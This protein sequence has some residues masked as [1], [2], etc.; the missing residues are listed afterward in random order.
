MNVKNESGLTALARAIDLASG[1]LAT[2][3][4]ISYGRKLLP[5]LL[6]YGADTTLRLPGS[7][8]TYDDYARR[9]RSGSG[10]FGPEMERL[11]ARYGR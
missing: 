9:S 4:Q 8:D 2:A 5:L 7:L 1:G 3:E 10:S 6:K 11:K